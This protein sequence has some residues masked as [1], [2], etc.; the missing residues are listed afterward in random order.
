MAGVVAGVLR[1]ME[2]LLVA[3]LVVVVGA[4]GSSVGDS[5]VPEDD[6]AARASSGCDDP[7]A[8]FAALGQDGVLSS[9]GEE[10]RF[11]VVVPEG[12]LTDPRPLV[13]SLPGARASRLQHEQMTGFSRLAEQEGFVLLVPQ[14]LGDPP[15]WNI[16]ERAPDLSFVE[17][18]I[19]EAESKLC[20]DLGHVYATGFS[21]GGMMSMLLA[22]RG[23]DRYAAIA[24]VAGVI[25]VDGCADRDT[26][27]PLLAFQGTDD[28]DIRLDGSYS[29]AASWLGGPP[30]PS[31]A[32]LVAGWAATN[33][34]GEPA[35]V[36]TVSEHVEE[37]VYE[38][39]VGGEVG[40]YV[41]Q[42]GS[43]SWPGAEYEDWIADIPP[44][45]QEISA[46]DLIWKFFQGHERTS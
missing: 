10:W 13:V 16:S 14:A 36:T 43:H 38:C 31:R 11:S 6:D 15:I 24:P 30:G 23:P 1:R 19:T 5:S 22:C 4:C 33:G 12:G 2:P 45:T 32:D 3:L 27:V 40:F 35:D 34:C 9:G 29:E 25:H 21:L 26:P 17:E 28:Q 39:P 18:L 8:D 42:G 37:Q 20:I 44:P 41:V 7:D 46:T